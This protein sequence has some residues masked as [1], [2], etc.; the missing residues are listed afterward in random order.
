M[1]GDGALCLAR[2]RSCERRISLPKTTVCP[3][4]REK[5]QVAADNGLERAQ[6]DDGFAGREQL[7]QCVASRRPLLLAARLQPEATAPQAGSP[8][9]GPRGRGLDQALARGQCRDASGALAPSRTAYPT[10]TA[11]KRSKRRSIRPGLICFAGAFRGAR[12]AQ[13]YGARAARLGLL[14][15]GSNIPGR[16]AP[17]ARP[18]R[19]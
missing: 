19:A 15:S 14:K 7:T 4:G 6:I 8:R 5:E 16:F 12:R 18:G 13:D 2:F 9:A 1:E 11:R 10:A 3:T 17:P